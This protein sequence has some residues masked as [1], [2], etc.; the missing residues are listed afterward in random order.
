MI[1]AYSEL[2]GRYR[3]EGKIAVGGMG[4]VWRG[5]DVV[6]DRPVAIKLLHGAGPH[7]DADAAAR[8]RAEARHVGSLSHSGIAQVYDYR[9]A[10]LDFPSFLVMELV[11]GPSL[12]ALVS[13]GPLDPARAMDIVAQAAA[14]LHE[15]HAA[16]LVHRDI[17]PPNLLLG[18]GDQ[19]KIIDFGIAQTTRSADVTGTGSVIGS[20]AYLAPERVRGG[21]ATAASDLY[22]LGIVAYECLAGAPPFSGT[23]M[24]VA[25]AHV[26][27]PM[28]PL[29]PDVP[30][31]IAPF[32][33]RLT[34]K[35][36]AARPASAAD[37]AGQARY[38]RDSM[39]ANRTLRLPVPHPAWAPFSSPGARL[40]PDGSG[41]HQAAA[42]RDPTLLDPHAPT[43]ERPRFGLV[44]PVAIVAIAMLAGLVGWQLKGALGTGQGQAPVGRPAATT[45]PGHPAAGTVT[46]TAATLDGQSA[47]T[48]R[49]RLVQ[50]GLRPRLVR[51]PSDQPPGTVLS[52]TPSGAVRPGTIVV[53]TVAAGPH[54][55]DHGG[56]DHGGGGG[57]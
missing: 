37:V 20:P 28:P 51:Q 30:E 25:H 14:A 10:D 57:D 40:A 38:L 7:D 49:R 36:P 5:T 47:R 1:R 34:A 11:E 29:P 19:V 50:L 55:H 27:R 3:L 4:E 32:I 13:Q 43:R 9:E 45:T 21:G 12:A 31:A 44:V 52:V 18:P 24:E 53:V 33:E 46:V 56:H 54:G 35:D 42:D 17:K 26:R 41:P 15:A 48:A 16:G 8:F 22:S 23:S 39:R 2:A 6:L